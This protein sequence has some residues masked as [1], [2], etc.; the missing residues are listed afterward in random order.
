M[1]ERERMSRVE[2]LRRLKRERPCRR[3]IVHAT[4]SVS[5]CVAE[6]VV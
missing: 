2:R 4:L 5:E 6:W 3:G 1:R